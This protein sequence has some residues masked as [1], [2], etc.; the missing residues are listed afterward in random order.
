[1]NYILCSLFKAHLSVCFS[2]MQWHNQKEELLLLT[3]QGKHRYL[4]TVYP[5]ELMVS[6]VVTTVSL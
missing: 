6:G 2:E 4:L 5:Q 1:M 3:T